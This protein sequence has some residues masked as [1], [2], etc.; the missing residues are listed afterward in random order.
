MSATNNSGRLSAYLHE[1]LSVAKL[2]EIS[3]EI[4][5]YKFLQALPSTIAPQVIA[6]QKDLNHSQLG[7]L[8]NELMPLS[9]NDKAFVVQRPL[10]TLNNSEIIKENTAKTLR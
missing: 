3:D 6:S 4:V 1:M 2:I 8:A 7:R 10:S 5:R 9:N